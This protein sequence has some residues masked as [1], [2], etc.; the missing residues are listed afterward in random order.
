MKPGRDH[1]AIECKSPIGHAAEPWKT[2]DILCEIEEAMKI[3]RAAP[4]AQAGMPT[5]PTAAGGYASAGGNANLVEHVVGLLLNIRL[6]KFSR[7]LV[8]CQ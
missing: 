8:S 2:F 6:M 3:T 5:W 1:A 7:F 4:L